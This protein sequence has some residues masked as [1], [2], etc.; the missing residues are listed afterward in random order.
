[1]TSPTGRTLSS[2]GFDEETRTYLQQRLRLLAGAVSTI[3]GLLA[4]IFLAAVW[5]RGDV[6]VV[7]AVY[8]FVTTLP[9]AALLPR[10]ASS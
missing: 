8:G 10:M 4:V 9:N 3:T 1:M 5:A 6:G 7:E 2:P